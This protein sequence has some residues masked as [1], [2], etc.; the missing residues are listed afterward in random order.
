MKAKKLLA[1]ILYAVMALSM[2]TACG[3]GGDLNVKNVNDILEQQGYTVEVK[4][5]PALD[6]A[7]N[8]TVGEMR[9]EKFYLLDTAEWANGVGSAMTTLGFSCWTIYSGVETDEPSLE[10]AAARCVREL[11]QEFGSDLN[12]SVSGQTL[13]DEAGTRYWVALAAGN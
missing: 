13:V 9:R 7:L 1:L 5:S 6:F 2:L 10:S 8:T 3:G 12:V 11:T 4:S